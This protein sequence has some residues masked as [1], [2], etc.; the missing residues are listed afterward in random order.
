M[1]N[2]IYRPGGKDY[3]YVNDNKI[4][5]IDN[6]YIEKL[7]KLANKNSFNKCTMCLHNDIRNNMHEMVNVYK[8]NEYV[9]PHFHPFKTETKMVMEGELLVIIFNEDGNIYDK[10]VLSR[11][12]E[13]FLFRMESG[14]IHTNIPLTDVVFY[15][16]ITGPFIGTDDSVFPDWAPDCKN[17]DSVSIF[18]KKIYEKIIK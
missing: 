18:M 14:V 7:K 2:N 16:A 6:L 5:K 4:L 1:Q 12:S 11:N 13:T 17:K 9:R 15:E 8:K 3:I 10:F